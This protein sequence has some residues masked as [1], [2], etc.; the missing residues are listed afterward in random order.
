M[1]NRKIC[2][3]FPEK[4]SRKELEIESLAV[5]SKL[6]IRLLTINKILTWKHSYWNRQNHE[7]RFLLVVV[8][9]ILIKKQISI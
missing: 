4:H 1:I 8:D 3:I 9:T 6:K 7:G 2:S 5:M